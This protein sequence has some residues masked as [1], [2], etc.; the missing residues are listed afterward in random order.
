MRSNWW[1]RARIGVQTRRASDKQKAKL[2]SRYFRCGLAAEHLEQRLLL[3]AVVELNAPNTNYSTTWTNSGA[4]AITGTSASPSL[5]SGL[6]EPTG[7][8]VSGANLWVV[9]DVYGTIG[10][11]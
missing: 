4:V 11:Y 2:P 1:S 9:N 8:A 3:S 10:E 7:I 6:N 5:V